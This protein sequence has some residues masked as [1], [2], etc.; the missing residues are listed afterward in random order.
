MPKL[1]CRVSLAR[2][3]LGEDRAFIQLITSRRFHMVAMVL[4]AAH[5][6]FMGFQGWFK[7]AGW[8][9]GLPPITLVAFAV[10]GAGFVINLLGRK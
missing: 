5:L 3:K 4:V 1:A 9:G 10:F 7:P 8:H 2:T 6:F